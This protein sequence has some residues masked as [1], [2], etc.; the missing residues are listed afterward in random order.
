MNERKNGKVER[1]RDCKALQ[2]LLLNSVLFHSQGITIN[3]EWYIEKEQHHW[4]GFNSENSERDKNYNQ[5]YME[6]EQASLS[7]NKES[8]GGESFSGHSS[9]DEWTEDR[10]FESRLTGN[11]DTCTLL[12]PVDVRSLCKTLS[13]SPGEGQTSFGL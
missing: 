12:H 9:S 1:F 7:R 13:F 3:Q 5:L 2:W 11:T 6:H 8:D 4:F 10:N